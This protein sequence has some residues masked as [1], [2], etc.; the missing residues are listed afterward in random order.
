MSFEIL[1]FSLLYHK[2]VYVNMAYT[3]NRIRKPGFLLIE[4]MC[5]LLLLLIAGSIMSFY[6]AIAQN[7]QKAAQKRLQALLAADKAMLQLRA[8]NTDFKDL[9]LFAVSLSQQPLSL[10]WDDGNSDQ[11]WLGQTRITWHQKDSI[12][13]STILEKKAL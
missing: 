4:I 1:V 8:G 9:G 10:D 13:L 5:A 2:K 12:S 11:V 6:V 7:R 3:A